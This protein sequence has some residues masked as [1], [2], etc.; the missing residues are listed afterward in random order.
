MF[1][2]DII[3]FNIIL[4]GDSGVVKD[5]IIKMFNKKEFNNIAPVGVS[6]SFKEMIVNKKDKIILKLVDTTWQEKYR[7]ITK[8]L[9]KKADAVLFVFSM[10]DKDSFDSINERMEDFKNNNNKEDVPKY[11]IGNNKDY[12]IYVEQSL[13]DEFT[14]KNNIPFISVSSKEK[15]AI[16]KLLEEI[17]KKL[18]LNYI[19]RGRKKQINTNKFKNFKKCLFNFYQLE[20]YINY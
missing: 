4:L 19:N 15:K 1:K 6:F 14:Q 3:T 17:G 7:A 11:L 2:K 16:D 5:S 12:G 20:K 9:Y 10:N 8:T 18:Y 13:I